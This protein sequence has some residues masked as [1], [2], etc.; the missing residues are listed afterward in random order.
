[1]IDKIKNNIFFKSTIVLL[2]GGTLT[3][4]VGFIL[5]IIITREI[6]TEGI[7]LYS[8]LSPTMSLLTVLAIFSYPT[9]VSKVISSSSTSAKRLFL[10]IIPISLIIDAALIII[11]IFSANILSSDLLRESRLYYPIICI[12]LTLPFVS[13]SSIIKGYFW[14]KQNMT[15]YM[16]SNFLEQVTRILLITLFISKF[17]EISLVY[18][19]CFIILVNI[20]GEIVSILIMTFYMPKYKVNKDDIKVNKND[21][22]S[23]MNVSIPSTSSKII[24]SFAYF[25]EPVILTNML[26]FMGYTKDYIIY[27]YGI[28]NAYALS[29]LL[30][31]QFFIQNMSTALIPEM[32]KYYS[33]GNKKMCKKRLSQIIIVSTIIG[34]VSTIIIFIFSK[35]FLNLLYHTTQGVDYIKLLAPFTVLYYIENPLINALQAIG[36]SKQAMK[37]TIY[38]SILRLLAIVIFSLFHTGMYSLVI[39]ININLVFSTFIYYKIIN[40]ALT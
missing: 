20:A 32:S 21:I 24:G 23:I 16:L 2:I 4:I 9:A 34:L 13:V 26:L 38:G 18:A 39:S 37:G 29:L 10:S 14:G 40:K 28:I 31:P 3:K 5:R 36:L 6:G 8:L 1:M 15:P 22:N 35:F 11:T 25:L 27:E 17:L 33:Q 12:S 7:G 30:M 19:I